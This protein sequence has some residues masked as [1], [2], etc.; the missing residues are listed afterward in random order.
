MPKRDKKQ[1]NSSFLGTMDSMLESASILESM[2]SS[3]VD[4]DSSA[5][6]GEALL[7]MIN[8]PLAN[9]TQSRR[10]VNTENLSE[11]VKSRLVIALFEKFDQE[12]NQMKRMQIGLF[13]VRYLHKLNRAGW[14]AAYGDQRVYIAIM[15]MLITNAEYPDFQ[16]PQEERELFLNE[17]MR[18]GYDRA[19]RKSI[20]EGL[21]SDRPARQR[22]G[23]KVAA[24]YAKKE[25]LNFLSKMKFELEKLAE[26]GKEKEVNYLEALP[27]LCDEE[28][29]KAFREPTP[30][31]EQTLSDILERGG[32]S[33][34]EVC[35]IATDLDYNKIIFMLGQYHARKAMAFS[36][37]GE[38]FKSKQGIDLAEKYFDILRAKPMLTD[39]INAFVAT[40]GYV[41]VLQ[42]LGT[43]RCLDAAVHRDEQTKESKAGL[44]YIELGVKYGHQDCIATL[45][46]LINR[47]VHD[48]AIFGN[49]L[50]RYTSEFPNQ[51]IR[52]ILSEITGSNAF[53]EE[54]KQI[55]KNLLESLTGS[56]EALAHLPKT[57][58]YDVIC[59]GGI[60]CN[61]EHLG[62]N[63]HV[64][65][66][67]A[68]IYMVVTKDGKVGQAPDFEDDGKPHNDDYKFYVAFDPYNAIN[69]PNC[70]NVL[71][72]RILPNESVYGVKMVSPIEA[73][74]YYDLEARKQKDGK[75]KAQPGKMAV[76]YFKQ[77]EKMKALR[78]ENYTRDMHY[79]ENLKLV[80]QFNEL[81]KGKNV[82]NDDPV[83]LPDHALPI[84]GVERPLLF[85]SGQETDENGKYIPSENRPENTIESNPY[86]NPRIMQALNS[87][88]DKSVQASAPA[89]DQ[90]LASEPELVQAQERTVVL[91]SAPAA[92]QPKPSFF[93]RIAAA[94]R[95]NPLKAGLLTA[96]AV[97]S[98]GL[99]VTLTVATAGGFALGA[100]AIA[101]AATALH[102]S[103]IG[104]SILSFAI[105][106]LASLGF[107]SSLGALV[108]QN[109]KSKPAVMVDAGVSR[110]DNTMGLSSRHI[111]EVVGHPAAHNEDSD[112]LDDDSCIYPLDKNGKQE[113]NCK[114]SEERKG[115]LDQEDESRMTSPRMG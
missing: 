38:P 3:L 46:E 72:E 101:A 48:D 37:T 64:A 74:N 65:S 33:S 17:G 26:S 92:S 76:I 41:D 87:G 19:Y 13:L 81:L 28:F 99:V 4:Q 21:M 25:K 111:Y 98:V 93:G 30:A 44:R 67:G 94:Y 60:E 12:K 55:A 39:K 91:D 18:I 110:N 88:Q 10:N 58:Q 47:D 51:K 89:Q 32:L 6:L 68:S 52:V 83:V 86:T 79:L 73:N 95:A 96:G 5:N 27:Q 14:N 80:I 35:Q 7:Q 61:I 20:L 54:R 109:A 42:Y 70:W 90:R 107:T 11:E 1:S 114:Q 84:Q 113:H 106:G 8:E 69:Y 102:I 85:V 78:G 57:L 2:V 115:T 31:L 97:L 53:T 15:D 22:E 29:L 43:S 16:I 104:M 103:T 66:N 40:K 59:K 105:S 108:K 45:L 56:S 77:Y 62:D 71:V 63:L 112:E 50:H 75:V 24:K 36:G 82:T 34:D 9:L 100:T 23:Y 49:I